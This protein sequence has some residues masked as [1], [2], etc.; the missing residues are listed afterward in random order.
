MNLAHWFVFGLNPND[1][2]GFR[3]DL[4]NAL[5]SEDRNEAVL[6]LCETYPE[7]GANLELNG[8]LALR[9]LGR[10]EDAAKALK[11]AV[12]HHPNT[13]KMLL[14]DKVKPVKSDAYGIQIGGNYQAWLYYEAMREEWLIAGAIAWAKTVL[15]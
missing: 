13:V 4:S 14:K 3:D 1:N 12:E 8:V 2:H 11:L 15:K 5:I 6:Q 9:C 10:K 7:D